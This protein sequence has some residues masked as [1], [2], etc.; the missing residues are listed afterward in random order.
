MLEKVRKKVK[1]CKKCSNL[2]HVK[3]AEGKM[4]RCACYNTALFL[5]LFDESGGNESYVNRKIVDQ[6]K[7]GLKGSNLFTVM[8]ISPN[9]RLIYLHSSIYLAARH[10][11]SSAV[12]SDQDVRDSVFN[13]VDISPEKGSM[14]RFEAPDILIFQL[15][16]IRNNDYLSKFMLQVVQRRLSQNKKT[17]LLLPSQNCINRCYGDTEFNTYVFQEYQK[18]M[19]VEPDVE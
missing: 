13:G 12:Y 19:L 6:I 14:A 17:V 3:N 2:R 1:D 18:Y 10:L 9:K 16:T 15:C 4:I 11:F 5:T 7:D 8:S